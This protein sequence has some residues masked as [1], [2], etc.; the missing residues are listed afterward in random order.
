MLLSS[1]LNSMDSIEFNQSG[2]S[3]LCLQD[4]ETWWG[5]YIF[6][7]V[8]WYRFWLQSVVTWMQLSLTWVPWSQS[9]FVN[10]RNLCINCLNYQFHLHRILLK[11]WCLLYRA[12]VLS[13]MKWPCFVRQSNLVCLMSKLTSFWRKGINKF[14]MKNVPLQILKTI[15]DFSWWIKKFANEEKKWTVLEAYLVLFLLDHRDFW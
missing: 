10:F 13:L 12:L 11:I 1:S 7:S 3:V 2:L 4:L 15:S 14:Y 9:I 6:V 5:S 8:R